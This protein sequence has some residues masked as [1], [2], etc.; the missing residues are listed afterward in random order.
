MAVS[1]PSPGTENSAVAVEPSI[2]EMEVGLKV[3]P[4]MVVVLHGLETS[5]VIETSVGEKLV[6]EPCP[7]PEP[8]VIVLVRLTL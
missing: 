1:T 5:I 4:V 3:I 7:W 8:T 6:V 2:T